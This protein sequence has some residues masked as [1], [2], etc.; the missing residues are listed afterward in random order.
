MGPLFAAVFV[1]LGVALL[2]AVAFVAA[3]YFQPASVAI[4]IAVFFVVGV[5]TGSGATALGL[6]LIVPATFVAPWQFIVYFVSLAIGALIGG[7]LLVVV[8]IK[9]RMLVMGGG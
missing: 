1:S 6:S 2:L 9:R 3:C 5:V 4:R 8:G 7:A